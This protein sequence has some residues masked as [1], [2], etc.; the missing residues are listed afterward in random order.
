MAR[1]AAPRVSQH[2]NYKVFIDENLI[3]QKG[4]Q[5]YFV[6]DL[7]AEIL[8]KFITKNNNE[9]KKVVQIGCGPMDIINDYLSSK[10]KN[11]D[12]IS[13]DLMED[14]TK[15]HEKEFKN[16]NKKDNW[17]CIPGFQVDLLKEKK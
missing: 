16:F 10:F 17:H 15:I 8:Q 6:F 7:Y 13:N 3:L 4:N 12:F 1:P 11:I 14:L 9:I 2:A 5:E